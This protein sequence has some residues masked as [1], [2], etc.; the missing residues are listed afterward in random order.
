MTGAKV[1]DFR[2]AS[3][4]NYDIRLSYPSQTVFT[5]SGN[6]AAAKDVVH[7]T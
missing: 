4:R 7:V 2:L 3:S 1:S 6:L 5:G